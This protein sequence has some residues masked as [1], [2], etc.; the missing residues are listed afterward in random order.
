M[1]IQWRKEKHHVWPR[2]GYGNWSTSWSKYLK[3]ILGVEQ[4]II[5]QIKAM[6][7]ENYRKSYQFATIELSIH[8]WASLS[9]RAEVVAQSFKLWEQPKIFKW[10]SLM[11]GTI[12]FRSCCGWCHISK[13]NSDNARYCPRGYLWAKGTLFSAPLKELFL[14]LVLGQFVWK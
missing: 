7:L 8:C 10:R 6:K 14:V 2:P 13:N 5:D 11:Q 1:V 9:K 12:I 3:P 4:L